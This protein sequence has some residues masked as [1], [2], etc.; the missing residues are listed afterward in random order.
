MRF[1]HPHVRPIVR[2]LFTA[3]EANDVVAGAGTHRVPVAAGFRRLPFGCG[4]RLS[5]FVMTAGEVK[6][7]EEFFKHD[8]SHSFHKT[9]IPKLD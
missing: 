1:Q 4:E 9:S 6:N 5:R 2:K 3:I 8:T 7:L